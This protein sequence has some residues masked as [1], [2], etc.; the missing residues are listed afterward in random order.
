MTSTAQLLAAY[1][2]AAAQLGEPAVKRFSDAKTAERRTAAIVERAAAAAKPAAAKPVAAG[3]VRGV[4]PK[5][6]KSTDITCGRVVDRKE[7]QVL[8]DEHKACC[9]SCG[10]EFHYET[11]KA[12]RRAA[13]PADRAAAIARSWGRADV[14]AARAARHSVTV[15]GVGYR[16]V[17]EAFE[18]L[19]LPMGQHIRFRAQL[20]AAGKLEGFGRAWVAV[21][22]RP[23]TAAPPA[24][25][26]SAALTASETCKA[27]PRAAAGSET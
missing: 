25:G 8:V 12:L 21:K 1:N 19:S 6:G 18:K 24:E 17:R 14:A 26:L 23:P 20:K 9:H 22:A 15:D 5:C 11:G 27:A 16:S 2:A 4:C 13:A 3:Y 10:H 7:G